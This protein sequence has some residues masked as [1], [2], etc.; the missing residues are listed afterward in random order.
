[1]EERTYSKR[2][3]QA[4]ATRE[5]LVQAAHQV[6]AERGY[7][8]ATVGAITE[9]ANTAHGTFYLY[10]RNKDEAFTTVLEDVMFDV[11]DRVL[12]FSVEGDLRVRLEHALRGF[13][14]VFAEHRGVWRSLLE[15]A[16]TAPGLAE[17]WAEIRAGF[18]KR[19]EAVLDELQGAG[20]VRPLDSRTTAVALCAMGEW[21]AM[22]QLVISDASDA[23][24]EQ[25]LAT[26]LDVWHHAL[27]PVH[28]AVD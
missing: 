3:A 9:R 7:T 14:G 22:S 10:F 13:V 23:D 25:V 26:M 20:L 18:N 16:L 6:F 21:M 27:A 1:M 5:Q 4:A 2:Q 11:H 24:R 15:G 19:V 28:V 17:T 8:A 12:S